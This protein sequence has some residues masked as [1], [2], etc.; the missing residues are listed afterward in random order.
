MYEEKDRG[1]FVKDTLQRVLCGRWI[2]S[3]REI[4]THGLC[5]S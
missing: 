5:G 2:V 4:V 3:G 1:L